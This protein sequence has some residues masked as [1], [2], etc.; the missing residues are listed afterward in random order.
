MIGGPDPL[1]QF[2]SAGRSQPAAALG[3]REA[4]GEGQERAEGL[5]VLDCL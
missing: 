1:P 3:P 2:E 4:T 5:R